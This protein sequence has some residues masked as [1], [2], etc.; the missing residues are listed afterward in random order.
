MIEQIPEVTY[1][2]TLARTSRITTRAGTVSLHHVAPEVF[3]G[4]EEKKNGVKLASPEKALFDFAYLSGGRTRL[5]TSLPELE[6][7]TRF[8]RSELAKWL[9]RIPA[10]R[11]RT[12]T[13]ARLERLLERR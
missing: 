13:S 7:P 10:A 5:F 3:G 11:T 9:V 8:R 4:F 12:L 1:A 2:V 6:L